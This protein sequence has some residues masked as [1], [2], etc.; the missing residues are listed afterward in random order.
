MSRT[1]LLLLALLAGI[2]VAAPHLGPAPVEACAPPNC[3]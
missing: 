1:T 2:I 3:R